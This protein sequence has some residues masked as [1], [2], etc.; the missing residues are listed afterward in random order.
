M[1]RQLMRIT[2]GIVTAAREYLQLKRE[3]RL[4]TMHIAECFPIHPEAV[5]EIWETAL[6]D[7]RRRPN[8]ADFRLAHMIV[9]KGGDFAV[10]YI[11]LGAPEDQPS[12][13]DESSLPTLDR[14]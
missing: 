6:L 14:S 1:G 9:F 7:L 10:E 11:P 2:P 3:G 12:L 13:F 4:P 5:L 8:A